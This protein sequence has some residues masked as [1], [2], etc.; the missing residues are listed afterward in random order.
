MSNEPRAGMSIDP[1]M[2]AAYIDKRLSPEQRAEVEAQLA[3]DPDSYAVLVE[4]LKAQDA[5]GFD[6]EAVQPTRRRRWLI[7]GGLVAA[8]AA[9]IA[10]V[11]VQP[12]WW[13]GLRGAQSEAVL[14]ARLVDVVGAERHIQGRATGGF[15]FG[16]MRPVMRGGVD[17][18][19][20]NLELLAEA[21][22]LQVAAQEHPTAT[23]LHLWGVAQLMTGQIDGAV[24]ALEQA[25]TRDD[26]P[27]I[28]ADLSAA[29]LERAL[30][31]DSDDDL[32]RALS[33]ADRAL[34]SSP[35]N[36]EALFNRAMVLSRMGRREDAVAAWNDYLRADSTSGW[37]SIAREQLAQR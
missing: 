34:K 20:A 32:T 13:P 14:M 18:A 12:D 22:K 24:S 19:Q 8:A 17:S 30:T 35:A 7:A 33:A 36:A 21:G 28:S 3:A 10:V 9:V 25:A 16:P 29:Y 4:T 23:N 31:R 11:L 6:R 37:A 1:E 5:L 27:A 2:L 26:S 15:E